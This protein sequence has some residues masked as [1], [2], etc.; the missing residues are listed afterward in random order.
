MKVLIVVPAFPLQLE[1]IKGGVNS[2]LSNLLKGFSSIPIKVRVVSFNREIDKP[3]VVRYADNI[4][5]HYMPESKLPHVIN[6]IGRGAAMI[7]ELIKE[8]NPSTVHFAM[9]G[10]ILLTR[11]QGLA[12]KKQVVTIHGIPFA[13]AKTKINLKEKL[14]FYSNGLVELMFCPKNIIH[15]SSYSAAQYSDKNTTTTIIANAIDP[16]YFKIPF[17]TTTDNKLI[18]IG[19]IEA[20]KNLLYI[21]QA[22]KILVAK[23]IYFSLSVLGGFTDET[24]KKNVLEFIENN[25]LHNSVTL[26]GWTSQHH[27]QAILAQSDILVLASHQETLPMVI[28]ESMSAAKVVVCSAVGGVPEMISHQNDGFLFDNSSVNNLVI[29]LEKLY[30][31]NVLVESIQ[32]AARRKAA[33]IYHSDI[34]AKKTLSFYQSL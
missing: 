16:A 11:L 10:Y 4:T 12:G 1:A 6:F 23:K 28:A 32:I 26:H 27:L 34:V 3:V 18:Y 5:I 24:Y 9:S 15:I 25:D 2:A 19:S 17:K 21:L 20:R 30:N 7:R 33:L 22:L 31:N 29:I 13:E 14:V 8:F